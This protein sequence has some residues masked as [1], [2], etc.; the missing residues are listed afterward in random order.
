MN[1]NIRSA[2]CLLLCLVTLFSLCACGKNQGDDCV[3]GEC[4]IPE[5][6][7]QGNQVY[8]MVSPVGYHD[9][10]MIQQAPRLDT[11][12]GKTIA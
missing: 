9:I 8:A 2:L 12:E 6:D 11:L 4:S 3:D 10:E 5:Y 1:K 7:T